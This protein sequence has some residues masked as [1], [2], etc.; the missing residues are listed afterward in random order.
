MF[1]L[2]SKLKVISNTTGKAIS[3]SG[4]NSVNINKSVNS[5]VDMCQLVLPANMVLKNKDS[6]SDTTA[7]GTFKRGDK[8][9]V[10]LG[11]NGALE[12]EFEGFITSVSYTTPV[13]ILAEGYSYLLK[14]KNINRSWEQVTLREL[15]EFIAI[16]TG[17]TLS[18]SIPQMTLTNYRVEN[19]SATKVLDDLKSQFNFSVYFQGKTLY[20][21]LEELEANKLVTY[22]IG[23]NTAD[24]SG[25]KFK[26]A[27]DR[28]VQVICKTTSNDGS[29]EVYKTGD[30][31]GAVQEMVVKNTDLQTAKKQADD[32]LARIKFSGFDGKIEGFLQPYAHHGYTCKLVDKKYAERNGRFYVA[33]VAI[34]FG[35]HGARRG[36]EIT[37]KLSV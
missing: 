12:K 33:S 20:V 37:K 14:T 17:I 4:V 6:A 1:V 8:L 27:E 18:N 29:K 5:Y 28:R 23:W 24:V 34:S 32:L 21:G 7:L 13:E 19:A 22:R 16:G 15:C 2:T 35:I 10:E 26:S 36:L 30:L 9:I 3:W 31:D 25:L 11:Y